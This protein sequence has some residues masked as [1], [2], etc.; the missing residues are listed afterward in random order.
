[1][2]KPSNNALRCVMRRI[3]TCRSS[4]EPGF[5]DTAS[6][7]ATPAKDGKPEK[8]AKLSVFL[9][10]QAGSLDEKN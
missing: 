2:K 7:F 1:M 3:L 5:F 6:G 10:S 4:H 9:S 8:A